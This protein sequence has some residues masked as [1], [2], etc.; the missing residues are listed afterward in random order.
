M[1]ETAATV[2]ARIEV[3]AVQIDT[4]GLKTKD[5]R[6]F[7]DVAKEKV[8]ACKLNVE[9]LREVEESLKQLNNT[10]P[11]GAQGATP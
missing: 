11:N 4:K 3:L 1:Q 6:S 7:V 8:L 10:A 5:N 2:I 9:W